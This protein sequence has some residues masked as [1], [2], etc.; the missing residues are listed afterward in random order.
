MDVRTRLGWLRLYEQL[1]DAGTVCR[2]CGISRPTLRK[3]W[4]RYQTDGV[5]GLKD[6]SRR[7][8]RLAKQKV[9]T[10]QEALVLDLRRSRS[11]L[12]RQHGLGLSLDTLHRI[13][14]RHGEQHLKRPKLTRKGKKR[15]SRPVPGDRVQIDV[16]KIVPAVYQY[17]AIDDCSRY[18]VLG[19][20]PR[21]TAANTLDFLERLIEEMPFP[22]QRI[23]SDRGLEFFAE[24][25]QQRLIDW[26]IKFRPIKPRSPHLNGKVERSQRADLEE[27]WPTVDPRSPNIRERLDEWQHFWNWE[28]PH[29]ALDG[30]TPIDRTCELLTKIPSGDTVEAAYNPAKERI[31]VA[32][33][34]I[35]STLARVK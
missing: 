10:D 2:R 19:V 1:G 29:S 17:T 8:R 13:L 25:V 35:D 15:Y 5:A 26:A 9:F 14:V 21:R 22:I 7:P 20:Y 32:E 6:E 31:R 18:R 27:F 34:A 30:K 3:W 4:R 24:K 28:R 33:Y 16:C 12:L 23:Q 11:E